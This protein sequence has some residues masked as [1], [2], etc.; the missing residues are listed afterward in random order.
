MITHKL[1]AS[2]LFAGAV[3]CIA[4]KSKPHPV[5]LKPEITE[6][7]PALVD[8]A[9]AAATTPESVPSTTVSDEEHYPGEAGFVCELLQ[10][11]DM[12]K[13]DGWEDMEK[14][15]WFGLFK[16]AD[17][18]V[19]LSATAITAEKTYESGEHTGWDIKTPGNDD[20]CYILVTQYNN[21]FRNGA[22]EEV[23]HLSYVRLYP[24]TN[25]N[26][27]FKNV[28]YT[29]K[30]SGKK[31]DDPGD[32]MINY[33]L[34]LVSEK[35]GQMIEELLVQEPFFDD[36]MVSIYFAGDM[37]GDGKLDLLLNTAYKY[38]FSR[39]TLYLSKPAEAGHLL[40]VVGKHTFYG[41]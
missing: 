36:T 4:C 30:A 10:R 11:A 16:T 35:D 15:N 31:P 38:S 29:L 24:G 21:L 33:K 9:A 13:E 27:R 1:L 32:G 26:F 7:A 22:V 37:D 25:T 14:L 40:K 18:K 41:C 17:N 34:Y 5:D 23:K 8:S 28:E 19:Y 39:P 3:F 20:T 2:S 12:F 6:S